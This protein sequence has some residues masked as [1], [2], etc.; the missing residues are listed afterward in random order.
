MN[1]AVPACSQPS[2]QRPRKLAGL[3]ASSPIRDGT[4]SENWR[5]ESAREDVADSQ[6]QISTVLREG[7]RQE[8]K[9]RV[10]FRGPHP[11][12]DGV[13]WQPAPSRSFYGLF[14]ISRLSVV[15]NLE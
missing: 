9:L 4:N 7:K 1:E 15:A 11:N 10:F 14:I 12:L 6:V 5:V 3:T 2:A 8:G 13:F